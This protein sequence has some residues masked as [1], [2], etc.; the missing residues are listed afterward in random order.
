M[1]KTLKRAAANEI[2][3]RAERLT[4]QSRVLRSLAAGRSFSM[5]HDR[6]S[7][8]VWI[9][10]ERE[11][12]ARLILQ[13]GLGRANAVLCVLGVE[14]GE[15]TFRYADARRHPRQQFV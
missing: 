14:V 5:K 2:E 10:A 8:D 15:M 4:C 6:C 3:S 12:D 13:R 1:K 7:S 9:L 11:L